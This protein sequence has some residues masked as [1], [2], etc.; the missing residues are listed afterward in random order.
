MMRALMI[1]VAL[2]AAAGCKSQT[3][4]GPLDVKACEAKV[5]PAIDRIMADYKTDPRVV[6]VI[7][8]AKSEMTTACAQD[9]WSAAVGKCIAEAKDRAAMDQCRVGLTKDQMDHVK[10]VTARLRGAISGLPEAA[11]ISGSGSDAGSGS[12]GSGSAP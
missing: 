1:V 4:P 12:A 6:A 3:P 8:K 11:P 7:D 2:I 10:S 5:G 9:R